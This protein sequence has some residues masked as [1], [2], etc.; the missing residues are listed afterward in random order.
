MKPKKPHNSQR[1]YFGWH[2]YDKMSEN[3]DIVVIT[4]DLG[5]GM[6]DAIRD[7]FPDRFYNVGAAEQL[8]VGMAVGMA[9]KGKIPIC[10]SITPFLLYRPFEFIRNYLHNE[11]VAVKLVGSGR[12]DDYEHDGPSHHAFEDRDIM[13][14]LGNI[15]SRWP[16]NKSDIKGIVDWMITNESPTYVNLRR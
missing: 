16:E 9:L 10:Y 15:K 5:Y 4:A 13:K 3:E 6:F 11:K 1:G 2:L 8:M 7:D 14:V 12:D